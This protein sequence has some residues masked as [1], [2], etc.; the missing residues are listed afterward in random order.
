MHHVLQSLDS[1]LFDKIHELNNDTIF[2]LSV[3]I[4][5]FFNC[6][7]RELEKAV[8]HHIAPPPPFEIETDVS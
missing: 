7:K 1:K 2:P 8:V 4:K 6:L 3:K 5:D